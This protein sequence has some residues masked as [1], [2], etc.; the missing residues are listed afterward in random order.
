M[1]PAGRPIVVMGVSGSGKTTLGATLADALVRPFI[2]ADDLHPP[3]NKLLMA[4]GI[5][6]SDD[7]RWPWL[8]TVAHE[9]LDGRGH[10]STP[11]VA[12]SALK[13]AY[14]DQLR[15]RI[16]DLLFVYL[17]GSAEIIAARLTQRHHEYMPASLLASQVA[18][19]EPPGADEPH[20]AVAL[21][22]PLAEAVESV[23]AALEPVPGAATR[24]GLGRGPAES[25]RSL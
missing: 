22:T 20:I 6:L 7:D 16:P 24:A 25:N 8:E 23:A 21:E 17:V 13:R 4:A 14:R 9:I 12:C 11:V 3:A 1:T 18:I 19:L 5:P 2:D 10:G 15:T